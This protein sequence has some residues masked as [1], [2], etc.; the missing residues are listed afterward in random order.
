MVGGWLRPPALKRDRC[1]FRFRLKTRR[2]ATYFHYLPLRRLPSGRKAKQRG[3][4]SAMPPVAGPT[5]RFMA[6][7]CLDGCHLVPVTTDGLWTMGTGA[8]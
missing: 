4:T 6:V 7:I 3:V 1:D 2:G 5:L 8:V